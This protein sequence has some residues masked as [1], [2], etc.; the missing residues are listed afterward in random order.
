[1]HSKIVCILWRA[2][3]GFVPLSAALLAPRCPRQVVVVTVR[4]RPWATTSCR[5]RG[6][7]GHKGSSSNR[8]PRPQSQR[9]GGGPG[10]RQLRR[11][12]QSVLGPEVR[13]GKEWRK[14][15]PTMLQREKQ[16]QEML[17][18]QI[19]D[20]P[21][22]VLKSDPTDQLNWLLRK[23]SGAAVA[24]QYLS[25]EEL[26]DPRLNAALTETDINQ[27]WVT[28][29][30]RGSE[31][32]FRLAEPRILETRWP[33]ALRAPAFKPGGRSSKRPGTQCSRRA[34]QN[35][36][37]SYEGG[38]RL[39]KATEQVLTA[40]NDAY[41][42]ERRAVPAEFL[43]YS[44]AKRFLQSLVL[45]VMRTIKTDDRSLFQ[46]DHRFPEERCWN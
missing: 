12:C 8:L 6:I 1:M 28:D 21:E 35:R 34:R 44:D 37:V 32:V 20:I 11:V 23:M 25:S 18:R 3:I 31:F 22:N 39:M 4:V 29:G 24:A 13:L 9:R 7:F 16:I 42:S 2:T 45:G 5:M 27:I 46:N 26:P 40:L 43:D 30:G 41:P 17:Q 10:N 14:R 19:G 36:P 38:K 33:P 15:H